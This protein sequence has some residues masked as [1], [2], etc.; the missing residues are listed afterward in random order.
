MRISGE[1]RKKGRGLKKMTCGLPGHLRNSYLWQTKTKLDRI[2][3]TFAY[4]G[5]V[6]GL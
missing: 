1:N 6:R 2:Y 5:C 4:V 3:N